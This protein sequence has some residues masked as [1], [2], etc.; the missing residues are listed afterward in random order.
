MLRHGLFFFLSKIQISFSSQWL[1]MLVDLVRT[2]PNLTLDSYSHI[3]EFLVPSLYNVSA[4]TNAMQ[5]SDE[6]YA[7]SDIQRCSRTPSTM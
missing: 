3:L 6:T 2:S 7:C 5:T 4:V 1:H